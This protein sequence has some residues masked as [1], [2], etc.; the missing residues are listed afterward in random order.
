MAWSPHSK[1]TLNLDL[2]IL[3]NEIKYLIIG[4]LEKTERRLSLYMFKA[5]SYYT[6]YLMVHHEFI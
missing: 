1:E 4:N 2:T 5:V 6:P 3:L